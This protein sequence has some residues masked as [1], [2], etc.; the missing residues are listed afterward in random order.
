MQEELSQG[1]K[2]IA[3][4]D[5]KSRKAGT[6]AAAI[7]ALGNFRGWHE[8]DVTID[9]GACDIVMPISLCSDIPLRESEQQ[10]SG[11]EYEVANGQSIPNEGERRCLMM[12]RGTSRPKW[13]TYRVA[14]VHKAILSIPRAADVG[15]ECH[16][17][18]Q[19]GYLL[20]IW[21]KK[22]GAHRP[23]WKSLRNE[24]MEQGRPT[25]RN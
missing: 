6:N 2:L 1:D 21:S 10:R 17:N 22:E 23:G 19:G 20:D 24:G 18:A 11:L 4:F 15:Y 25:W 5:Y 8:I 12:T 16:L 9:S 13:I 14:E 3:A 7:S